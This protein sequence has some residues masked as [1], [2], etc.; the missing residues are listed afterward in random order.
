VLDVALDGTVLL[1]GNPGELATVVPPSNSDAT[2]QVGRQGLGPGE[3]Q[4]P[5]AGSLLAD[6][7]VALF[8]GARLTYLVYGATG[9]LQEE[10]RH[11]DL[12]SGLMGIAMHRDSPVALRQ[13]MPGPAID[14]DSID[15]AIVHLVGDTEDTLA[16]IRAVTVGANARGLSARGP[17]DP[18]PLWGVLGDGTVVFTESREPVITLISSSGSRRVTLPF[19]LEPVTAAHRS[20]LRESMLKAP[21]PPGQQA[22]R[23]QRIPEMLASLPEYHPAFSSSVVS[24][25]GTFWL[26]GPVIPDGARV[27]WYHLSGTGSLLGVL[28]LD[29]RIRLAG[30]LGAGRVL[31]AGDLADERS[32]RLVW[33][34]LRRN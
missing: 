25:D 10:R 2:R 1:A 18:S 16:G 22:R 4:Y 11:P 9:T 24:E 15:I 32:T 8:D 26:R 19:E 20:S 34:D 3:Y 13:S 30:A 31:L 12:I 23:D 6:G 33:F 21:A 28:E 27:M 14:G 7:G 29:R 17:F 5:I